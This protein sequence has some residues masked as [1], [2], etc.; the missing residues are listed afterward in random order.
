MRILLV[1]DDL[2]VRAAVRLALEHG[3]HDVLEAETPL[4]AMELEDG[5]LSGVDVL[6]TDMVMPG[7]NGR[8]LALALR[9]RRPELK[10]LFVSGYSPDPALTDT[11]PRSRYLTKPFRSAEL[12]RSLAQWGDHEDGAGRT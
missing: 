2:A 11:V 5:Q 8:D 4:A 3:G 12:L 1:E 7:C 6:V 10:V 9:A